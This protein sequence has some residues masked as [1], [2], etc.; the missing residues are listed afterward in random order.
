MAITSYTQQRFGAVTR[1]TV[2]S[3]L[4]AAV[5]YHWYLDGAWVARTI[6]PWEDF[7]LADFALADVTVID[8]ND[9]VFEPI[10]NQPVAGPARR[11]LWWIRSLATDVR[12]YR[13]QQRASLGEW[14]TIADV[15]ALGNTWEYSCTTPR[16]D[17]LTTYEWRVV[18]IDAV[19]NEGTPLVIESESVVRRPDPPDFTATFDEETLRVTFSEL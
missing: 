14:E 18:P 15:A 16:L 13:V 9:A 5:Y 8:T 1:V 4:A 17:D 2:E 11:T 6:T 7:F 10:Q 19:G 12:T 3:D